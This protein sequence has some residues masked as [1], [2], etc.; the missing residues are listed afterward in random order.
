MSLRRP[1]AIGLALFALAFGCQAQIGDAC[2]RSTDCSLTADRVCDLSV[3]IGGQGEC[4]IEGCGRGSCPDEGI[5]TKVYGSEFL[6]VS[7][8]PEREDRAVVDVDG[9][10]L[11]PRNDCQPHEVC[12]PE[13]LCADEQSARLS[14]RRKCSDNGDCRGG[15]ECRATGHRGVYWVPDPRSPQDTTQTRICQPRLR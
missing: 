4:T 3:R 8:D 5:C 11:G 7:C 13:G 14:C 10:V 1:H 12:L 9:Q 2:R 15:Y 6:S